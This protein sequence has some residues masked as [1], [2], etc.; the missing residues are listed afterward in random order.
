MLWNGPPAPRAAI[1]WDGADWV[2]A[3][4]YQPVAHA[5]IGMAPAVFLAHWRALT[6]GL[7]LPTRAHVWVSGVESWRRLAQRG[8]WVEGCAD[9]LG[10]A[11][12][13]ATLRAPVLRLPPLADWTVLTRTDAAATWEGTGVGRIVATYTI[14]APED[15]AALSHIRNNIAGA[16]HFFWGSATQYRALRAWL[17]ADSHHACGPGKTFQ[18]LRADGVTNLQ[19][20]PSRRE[21]QA[22]VA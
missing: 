2:Q 11:A 14:A 21:W 22:W 8:V 13:L 1:A 15:I 10:F 3:S 6:P 20:F 12:I 9:H 4:H 5:A 18:A 19:A 7:R 17:P 16:T